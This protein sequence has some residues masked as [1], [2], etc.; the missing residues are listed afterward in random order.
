MC[1]NSIEV[2]TVVIAL[3]RKFP[4]PKF[5]SIVLIDGTREADSVKELS[6][7]IRTV[8]CTISIYVQNVHPAFSLFQGAPE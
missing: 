6:T 8:I 1:V 3:A 5:I 4:Q 7:L 2:K